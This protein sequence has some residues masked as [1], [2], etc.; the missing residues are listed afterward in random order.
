MLAIPEYRCALR[1]A[2]QALRSRSTAIDG[3]IE[4]VES[5]AVKIGVRSFTS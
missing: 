3:V 1:L 4:P 2:W 5:A